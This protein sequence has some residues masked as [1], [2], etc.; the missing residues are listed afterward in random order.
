MRQLLWQFPGGFIEPGESCQQTAVREIGEETGV[1]TAAVL[2]LGQ[3]V[4]PDTHR[5]MAY[6]VCHHVSGTARVAAPAEVADIAWPQVTDLASYIPGGVFSLVQSY[7]LGS[8]GPAAVPSRH[9]WSPRQVDSAHRLP[10]HP[11]HIA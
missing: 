6:V 2:T 8:G 10:H 1:R 7:V 3:R 11:N 5:V 9:R 4:H